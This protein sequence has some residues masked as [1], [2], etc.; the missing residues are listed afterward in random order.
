MALGATGKSGIIDGFIE[1]IIDGCS[2]IMAVFAK[3]GRYQK[4]P[5]NNQGRQ[6]NDEE[7]AERNQLLRKII[8]FHGAIF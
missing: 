1:I 7:N 2:S 4:M 5:G 6:S 3:R 8:F